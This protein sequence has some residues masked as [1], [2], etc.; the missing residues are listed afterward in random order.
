MSESEDANVLLDCGE[1]PF[2]E[3]EVVTEGTCDIEDVGN[4]VAVET[5]EDP[6]KNEIGVQA[7]SE[8]ADAE[9]Q[10]HKTNISGG[11]F[12]V[13]LLKITKRQ[14]SSIL[15]SSTLAISTIFLHA[16]DQQ[17]TISSTNAKLSLDATNFFSL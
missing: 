14:L 6:S 8:Q 12:G 11:K 5:F 13:Q 17:Q 1:V 10:T 3:E 2:L 9:T 15:G 7:S 16:L 4:E